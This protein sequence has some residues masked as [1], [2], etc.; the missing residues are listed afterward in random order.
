MKAIQLRLPA[1]IDSLESVEVPDPGDPGPGQLRVR[2][3]ASSL[4]AHDL[5]VVQGRMNA[6]SGRVPM[7]DGAGIVE[8]IGPGVVGFAAGDRVVS[9]FFPSWLDGEPPIADFSTT[10]G[11]GVDG[12]ACE[13]VVRP[14]IG[15]T[16]APEGY[17]HAQAATLS[18]AALTAWRALVVNGQL[19]AGD[20]VLVL[21]TG[22][23]SIFGLQFAKAM[24]ATVIATSS[25]DEKLERCRSLGA[26]HAINY[27]SE[28]DWGMKVRELTGGRGVDHI[29][30]VGGPGTLAQSIRA[31]RIGGHI[32]LI[33]VLTGIG[34]DSDCGPDAA[35]AA[36]AGID[37]GQPRTAARDDSGAGCDR[38]QAGDRPLVSVGADRR[39]VSPAE[40]GRA[41]RE[42]RT[43]VLTASREGFP[44]G[45]DRPAPIR[46]LPRLRGRPA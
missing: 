34:R 32:S 20:S 25:S 1:S 27:R 31:G 14:A 44:T 15:F 28:P 13:V 39:G 35:A 42:D 30:E 17:S 38:N 2:I 40:D 23:V 18:T 29:L 26:D 45:P 6:P 10:P 4:N 33:G 19:K 9:T 41:L 5:A 24:G 36:I 21:G 12:F 3:H 43:G 11:D 37:C 22:G 7:A 46:P 16:H 8:A